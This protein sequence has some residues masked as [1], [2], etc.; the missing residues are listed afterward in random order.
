MVKTVVCPRCGFR[1][2]L[3]YARVTACRGCP[4]SALSCEYVRCPRCGHEFPVGRTEKL[5][6]LKGS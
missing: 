1:F 6:F 5:P 3:S 4:M 2:A